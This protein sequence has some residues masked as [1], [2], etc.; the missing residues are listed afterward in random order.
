[1]TKFVLR[2]SSQLPGGRHLFLRIHNFGLVIVSLLAFSAS[3]SAQ[4]SQ[5]AP[6]KPPQNKNVVVVSDETSTVRIANPNEL[7]G[8]N[9]HVMR[10][11]EFMALL[12]ANTSL[13]Q[14][15]RILEKQKSSDS[16]QV[17]PQSKTHS[18]SPSPASVPPAA[19]V[20]PRAEFQEKH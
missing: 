5:S 4:S 6:A 8:V 10:V 12:S 17:A 13:V 11:A 20:P 1:M 16:P 14:H 3:S 9:G 15:L 7:I 18:D 19:P 2:F